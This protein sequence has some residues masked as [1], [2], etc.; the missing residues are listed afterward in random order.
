M[1]KLP[2][3]RRANQVQTALALDYGHPLVKAFDPIAVYTPL[4]GGMFDFVAQKYLS[5]LNGAAIV[6]GHRGMAG[7]SVTNA[8][9]SAVGQM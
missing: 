4:H 1:L 8:V 2:A 9:D 6:P 7:Y 3:K 5:P